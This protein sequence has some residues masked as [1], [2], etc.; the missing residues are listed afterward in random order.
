M[1][2]EFIVQFPGTYDKNANAIITPVQI[3][4]KKEFS[5][6][7]I[8]SAIA[9]TLTIK[10][11]EMEISNVLMR[12]ADPLADE[13]VTSEIEIN[14]ERGHPYA[15]ISEQSLIRIRTQLIAYSLI[16]VQPEEVTLRSYVAFSR[17]D[18]PQRRVTRN[19]WIPTIQGARFF[20]LRARQI[21]LDE[22]GGTL[23]S[24]EK[25]EI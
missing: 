5:W 4:V 2:L 6:G 11:S 13:R 8:I 10:S 1:Q 21:F 16:T 3:E 24:Q 22:S 25:R 14:V 15:Q 12:M 20:A 7:S 18:E 9:T 23:G 17:R 19:F